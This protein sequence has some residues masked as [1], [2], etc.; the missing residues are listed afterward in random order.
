MKYFL[1]KFFFS[2][3]FATVNLFA[4][5]IVNHNCTKISQIPESAIINAKN[6]LHIT[7]GHTSHGSQII[8]GM[9]YL[10]DFLG[11]TGLYAWSEEAD[12]SFL[13]IDDYFMDGDLGNPDRTTWAERTRTY[14]NDS[15]NSEI[16]VVMWSWCGQ[17]SSASEEDI[18]TYLN[19][20]NQLEIDFPNVKF[21]YMTGHLDGSGLEGN[22]HLRNE[23]IRNFCKTNNKILF[24]FNDIECYDP[25]GNYF[26]D[27]YPNDNCDYDSD[28]NGSP[29]ANWAIDW[30]NSHTENVDWYNCD[31]AHSQALNGNQKAYAAW[32]LWATL[33]GWNGITSVENNDKIISNFTLE[34]NY[35]N[36]FNPSTN[37]NFN[38]SKQANV[39]LDIFN[40]LGELVTT[41]TNDNYNVGNYSLSWNGKD[42]NGN[43][44]TSGIYF[45]K[46]SSEYF[47]ATKSMILLK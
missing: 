43:N 2:L 31:A 35:P 9:N 37:I 15:Q 11:A 8:S 6:N 22:L 3:F 25:D 20:M 23:Q 10:D 5:I 18:N 45:Y 44:A 12:E 14:L 21:V 33:S 47:T 28:G 26:G 41:I 4:Q 30:Q 13:H 42:Q 32:W 39:R 24:D 17:V 46:L 29:D 36:P 19:L 27:K 1:Q 38:I 7:Y 34:N 16:N 40:S